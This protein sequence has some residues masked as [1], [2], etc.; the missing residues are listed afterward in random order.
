MIPSWKWNV[1]CHTGRLSSRRCFKFSQL[2]LSLPTLVNWWSRPL[3]RGII[4]VTSLYLWRSNIYR[5]S[6]RCKS[7]CVSIKGHC[8]SNN[9]IKII[10]HFHILVSSVKELSFTSCS[11]IDNIFVYFTQL[12]N[13]SFDYDTL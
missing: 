9:H 10:L 6:L 1:Y 7:N 3:S 13:V 2:V 4:V 11:V 8:C 5:R 12:L